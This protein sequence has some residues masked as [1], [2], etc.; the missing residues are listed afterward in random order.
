MEISP[1]ISP[2]FPIPIAS[3]RFQ[4]TTAGSCGGGFCRHRA[5]K[6]CSTPL[7]YQLLHLLC[8]LTVSADHTS[9]ASGKGKGATP[10]G[11]REREGE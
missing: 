6:A 7:Y 5:G 9:I 1:G 10:Q 4:T 11:L 8:L 2:E 3:F